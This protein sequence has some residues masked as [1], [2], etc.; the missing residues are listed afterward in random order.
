MKIN[1]FEEFPTVENL[2]K[3]KLIDFSS[4][5]Y[6]AAKSLKQF[7]I[8]EKRLHEINPKL[9]AG[10]WPI[11]EKSYWISPFSYTY[12]LKNLINELLKNKQNKPFEILIDL[13]LPFLSKKLFLENFASFHKNKKLVEKLFEKAINLNIETLTAEYPA[14]SKLFQKT[15]EWLGVSYPIEKYSHKKVV[16]LYSS[17]IKNK[18]ILNRMKNF[19]IQKSREYGKNLQVGLGTIAKGILGN[20]PILSPK[21]LDN[22]LKFLRKNEIETAVIFRLGGLNKKYTEIIQKYL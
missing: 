8:L 4:T 6:I 20:E 19:I 17:L 12:E 11:L 15:L 9:K 18:F 16:M 13:E 5:I 14:T 2:R 1:F 10:Y 22:D 7:K 3:A 21:Q